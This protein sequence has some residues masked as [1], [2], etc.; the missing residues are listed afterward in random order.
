MTA[1]ERLGV[2]QFHPP[3]KKFDKKYGLQYAQMHIIFDVKHK[4]FR[5]KDR[6]VFLGHVVDS[7]STPHINLP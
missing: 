4:D 6:L 2:F 7:R 5:H 3:K 1:S